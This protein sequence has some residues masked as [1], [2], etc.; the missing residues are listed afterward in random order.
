MRNVECGMWNLEAEERRGR[1][2]A[3]FDQSRDEKIVRWL[4]VTY[5]C[6]AIDQLAVVYYLVLTLCRRIDIRLEH[7]SFAHRWRIYS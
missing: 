6:N 5:E 2:M 3:E 1:T 7:S 4:K